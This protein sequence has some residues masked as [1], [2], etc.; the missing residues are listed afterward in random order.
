MNFQKIESQIT[1]SS[2]SLL[3]Y[4]PAFEE[5]RIM[6][7]YYYSNHFEVERFETPYIIFK[8]NSKNNVESI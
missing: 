6:I 2:K 4:F 8:I 1:N 3:D 7:K 5:G